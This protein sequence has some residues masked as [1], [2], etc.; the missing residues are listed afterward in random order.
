MGETNVSTELVD[1]VDTS[2][3]EKAVRLMGEFSGKFRS[4]TE[5]ARQLLS[6]GKPEAKTY[7]HLPQGDLVKRDEL[8]DFMMYIHAP[9][10]DLARLVSGQ[11]EAGRLDCL[12]KVELRLRLAEFEHQLAS[13]QRT[14]NELHDLQ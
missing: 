7:A 13:T 8:I 9:A 3:T 5:E 1:E 6:R 12:D 14:V 11:I 10:S 4:A 2:F